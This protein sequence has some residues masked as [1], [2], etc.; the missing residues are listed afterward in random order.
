MAFKSRSLRLQYGFPFLSIQWMG[1]YDLGEG[2][3]PHF[4]IRVQNNGRTDAEFSNV[5]MD[6][7]FL[8]HSPM[9][10]FKLTDY[11]PLRPATIA[12]TNEKVPW[13]Q[14]Q[15]QEMYIGAERYPAFKDKKVN[16]YMWGAIKYKN[17]TQDPDT[18]T[19]CRYISR[20]DRLTAGGEE[21]GYSGPYH[22]CEQ[23]Q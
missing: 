4:I 16:L 23:T 10:T 15:R 19:F 5:A 12:P 14:S 20:D 21:S 7:Q 13:I 18:F 6:I 1:L 3:K 8:D 9:Q 22:D 2:K 17:F 11:K